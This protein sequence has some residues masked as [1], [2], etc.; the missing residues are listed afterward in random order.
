MVRFSETEEIANI[1][2]KWS[3]AKTKTTKLVK[4]DKRNRM[5]QQYDKIGIF[6]KINESTHISY[7]FK[8]LQSKMHR[9][10]N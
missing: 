5:L 9:I 8:I 10:K 7:T 4:K 3:I 6:C 1:V 2:S